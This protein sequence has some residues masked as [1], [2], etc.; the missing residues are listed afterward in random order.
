MSIEKLKKA[1]LIGLKSERY[2]TLE[3]LQELG[4]L[5]LLPLNAENPGKTDAAFDPLPI[6]DRNLLNKGLQA[7]RYLR[8]APVVRRQVKYPINFDMEKIVDEVLNNCRRQRELSDRIDYLR[9]KHK[10]LLPWGNFKLP[11]LDQLGGYRFWFYILPRRHYDALQKLNLPW[12]IVHSDPSRH[13]VVILSPEEPPRNL[14]P[15][16]RIHL[17]EQSLSETQRK[18]DEAESKLDQVELEWQYL[19]RWIMLLE[20]DL[21]R[22]EDRAELL[23]A[24]SQALVMDPLFLI[25]GWVPENDQSKLKNHSLDN[26]QALLLE[27]PEPGQTPPTLMHPPRWASAGSDLVSFY[28]VPAYEEWDPSLTVFLSFGL[29]FGIMV[30]DAGYAAL[31]M[32][33]LGIFWRRMGRNE[34]VK[35]YRPLLLLLALFTLIWGGLTGS[36]FG[37]SP[38]SNSL[39]A[40]LHL[41]DIRDYN[42]IMHL[43][44]GVGLL[45][46]AFANLSQIYINRNRLETFIPLGWILV[47]SGSVTAWIS[48]SSP[49]IYSGFFIAGGLS[50][51]LGAGRHPIHSV[52]DLPLRMA[53]GTLHLFGF[54]KLFGDLLSYLRLFAL[55]LATA[56][57]AITF[58]ELATEVL[59]KPTGLSILYAILIL[60]IGHSL[61]LCLGVIG[62]IVHG[63]RLN[64]IEFFNWG[65]SKEGHRFK[66]FNKRSKNHA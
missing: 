12:Q 54:T 24:R 13:W 61:N 57:L 28:R 60:L 11:P 38:P 33:L 62:G 51:A 63:L 16:S 53:L 25:Q 34:R 55:G 48:P 66:H 5:H 31:L 20:I 49:Q 15:V 2:R 10:L 43:C 36:Y 4:C 37:V 14:L 30:G 39:L 52:K 17:G 46:I 7:L 26:A 47:L 29:F 59:S 40:K 44:L 1:S 19:T 18:L 9:E 45:H 23:N 50:I 42:H 56:S 6:E 64:Y 32:L 35:A 41:L 65:L 58:N 27:D 21:A 8:S 3:A 22:L